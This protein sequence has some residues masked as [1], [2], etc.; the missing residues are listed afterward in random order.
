MNGESPA[1]GGASADA[2]DVG[3][4]STATGGQGADKSKRFP[5]VSVAVLQR[6]PGSSARSFAIGVAIGQWIDAEGN[7]PR[8]PA[9]AARGSLIDRKRLPDVLEAV[10]VTARTWRE[11]VKEWEAN[12]IAHKCGQ[13]IVCLLTRPLQDRCPSCRAAIYID[14]DEKPAHLPRGP[15][16]ANGVISAESCNRLPDSNDAISATQTASS[17]PF[18]GTNSAVLEDANGTNSAVFEHDPATPESGGYYGKEVGTESLQPSKKVQ[19]LPSQEGS[20]EIAPR[21]IRTEVLSPP[22]RVEVVHQ[23]EPE[24]CPCGALSIEPG[25]HGHAMGCLR[26]YRSKEVIGA[27]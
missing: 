16:F 15:G 4:D 14:H 11:Y 1:S 6:L 3:S 12:Y 19:E 26:Y 17:A 13:S 23:G 10:G 21:S 2:H 25:Y 24:P 22:P 18:R 9:N 8:M 20:S 5:P 7:A 27:A